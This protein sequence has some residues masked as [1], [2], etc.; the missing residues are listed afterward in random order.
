MNQTTDIEVPHPSTARDVDT[1]CPTPGS[2]SQPKLQLT[3]RGPNL[4]GIP[5]VEVDLADPDWSIFK[6]VQYVTQVSKV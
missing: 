6:A 3:L 2:S 1:V 4:P 5:D